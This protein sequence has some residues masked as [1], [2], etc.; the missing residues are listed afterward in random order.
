MKKLQPKRNY[1]KWTTDEEN[2]VHENLGKMSIKSLAETMGIS[3]ASVNAKAKRIQ[4]QKGEEQK[5]NKE[6]IRLRNIKNQQSPKWSK[7]EISYIITNSSKENVKTISNHLGR[8]ENAVRCKIQSL[9]SKGLLS[10]VQ[11]PLVFTKLNKNHKTKWSRKEIKYLKANVNTKSLK[12]LS[13][14]LGRS[15][16]AISFKICKLQLKKKNIEV[17]KNKK[18]VNTPV[19]IAVSTIALNLILLFSFY[20]LF[21]R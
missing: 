10:A 13:E 2:F 4:E 17:S 11:L 18:K 5:S 15:E 12:E 19:I 8:S 14:Y 6:L 9:K 3:R 20:I 16:G 7:K 21:I 1:H